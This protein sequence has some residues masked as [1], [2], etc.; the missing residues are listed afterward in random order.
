MKII[1]KDVQEEETT[2]ALKFI[3]KD[4]SGTISKKEFEEYLL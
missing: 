4:N 2:I 1:N 3:D